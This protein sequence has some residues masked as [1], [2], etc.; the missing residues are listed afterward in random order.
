MS[1]MIGITVNGK[2][3]KTDVSSVAELVRQ[4]GLKPEALVAELNGAIVKRD[5]WEKTRLADGDQIE[6]IGFVGGG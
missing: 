2:T 4:K 3:E 1:A 5:A 6:L